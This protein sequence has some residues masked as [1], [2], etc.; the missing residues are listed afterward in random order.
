VTALVIYPLSYAI[1]QS[2]TSYAG[3]FTLSN[4]T[5]ALTSYTFHVALWNTVRYTVLMVGLEILIGLPVALALQEIGRRKRNIIRALLLVPLLIAPVVAAYEWMWLLNDQYG[6]FSQFLGHLGITAPLWLA[7]PHWAFFTVVLV[8]VWSAT[9]FSIL[10]FQTTLMAIPEDI[11][12][13]ARVDGAN[14]L[15]S[16]WYIT[17]PL[18][19][20]A[21]FIILIIR[22]MDAFRIYDIIQVLTGGGPGLATQSLSTLTVKT[23]VSLGEL[24][25]A[26][27]MAVLTLLPILAVTLLYIRVIRVD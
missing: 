2:L 25:Q 19:K 20:P 5:D 14:R 26:S 12:E 23:G 15:R 17:R 1:R 10:I 13:A 7:N 11:Y 16:F 22:T 3:H 24:N 9:P 21:F 4:F 27:A 18:L 8:D 6:L